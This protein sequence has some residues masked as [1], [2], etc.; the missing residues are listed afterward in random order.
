MRYCYYG[1]YGQTYSTLLTARVVQ[2][3]WLKPVIILIETRVFIMLM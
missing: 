2:A 1:Y 3:S